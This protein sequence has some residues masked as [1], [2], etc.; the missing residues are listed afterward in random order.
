[1]LKDCGRVGVVA[2]QAVVNQQY[3]TCVEIIAELANVTCVLGGFKQSQ[4]QLLFTDV[5]DL[6]M[7]TIK[8]NKTI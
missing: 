1:M 8:Q 7:G 5:K 4:Y 3:T 6:S 2:N